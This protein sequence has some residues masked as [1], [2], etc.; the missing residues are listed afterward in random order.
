MN[1]NV[2]QL[3]QR[4]HQLDI[5]KSISFDVSVGDIVGLV[6]RNGS[7]KTSLFKLI[8]GIEKSNSG[9]I[10][11][12]GN[13][14]KG[15]DERL[16]VLIGGNSLYGD[17]NANQNIDI[18][19]RYYRLP[20][21]I[22][23]KII[24]LAGLKEFAG[25]PIKY[26]SD[27]MKQRLSIGIT[28]INNPSLVVLDEPLNGL[29]PES[30]VDVRNLIK[31]ISQVNKTTF[32]ISSH[33]LEEIGKIFNKLLIL[34]NGRLILNESKQT[35]DSFRLSKALLSDFH[36]AKFLESLSQLNVFYQIQDGFFNI[37]G[38]EE[39]LSQVKSS[40]PELV[41]TKDELASIEQVYLFV[42]NSLMA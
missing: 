32:I 20:K 7:G 27:G 16:G 8:A 10:L 34:K 41:W 14:R 28:C 40:F 35:L 33:S 18:I 25:R 19:R 6:G 1:L 29:D 37:L 36:V 9:T 4:K 24:D 26:Y 21:E 5:L 13:P 31:H 23:P 11:F 12:N 22:I 39:L 15:I 17:L 38:R 2:S 42:N 3:S 30:I